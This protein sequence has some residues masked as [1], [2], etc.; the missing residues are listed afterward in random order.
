MKLSSSSISGVG[1]TLYGRHVA[2]DL[3]LLSSCSLRPHGGPSSWIVSVDRS[4]AVMKDGGESN[5]RCDVMMPLNCSDMQTLRKYKTIL[6]QPPMLHPGAPLPL[7]DVSGGGDR[8]AWTHPD[9]E[10]SPT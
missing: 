2:Y 7:P 1:S 4:G 8:S 5:W 6:P 9:C 10:Q 3:S